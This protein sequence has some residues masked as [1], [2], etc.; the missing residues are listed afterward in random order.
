MN[1]IYLRCN[2]P[3]ESSKDRA[4]GCSIIRLKLFKG[5]LHSPAHQLFE[6]DLSPTA[7][8]SCFLC[9]PSL[10]SFATGAR[11][12]PQDVLDNIDKLQGVERLVVAHVSER[13]GGHRNILRLLAVALPPTLVNKVKVR[14]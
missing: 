9:P 5:F 4:G 6:N 11:C 7:F 10:W 13:H 12:M 2:I 1:R 14:R 3:T 8:L